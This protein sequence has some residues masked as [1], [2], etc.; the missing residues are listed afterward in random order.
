MRSSWWCEREA[1]GCPVDSALRLATCVSC[2]ADCLRPIA[3]DPYA[4]ARAWVA[5]FLVSTGDVS[6]RPTG[7][8]EGGQTSFFEFAPRRLF[9][10]GPCLL[11]TISRRPLPCH[12]LGHSE[13][14]PAAQSLPQRY[15][16]LLARLQP[17]RHSSA[18]PKLV[19]ASA[20]LF[21]ASRFLS[22]ESDYATLPPLGLPLLIAC[23]RRV[24]PG[25]H[26]L[27][28][29]KKNGSTPLLR[30]QPVAE[31]LRATSAL[32]CDI[33]TANARAFGGGVRR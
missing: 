26:S 2:F 22:A 31:F 15:Y 19:H 24:N 29:K 21:L 16:R 28:N 12:P 32:N 13:G 7:A 30:P 8:G 3:A 1:L 33:N 18:R 5:S 20:R 4:P 25:G 14:S 10:Y 17:S 23:W 27:S 11:E 9:L 6:I